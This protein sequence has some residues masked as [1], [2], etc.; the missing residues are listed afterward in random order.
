V[1]AILDHL[2]AVDEY[3]QHAGRVLVRLDESAVILDGFR[4]EDDYVGEKTFL[5]LA[6]SRRPLRRWRRPPNERG[7][8]LHL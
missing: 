7:Q 4:I 8:R 2:L 5:E 3:V 1:L 6:A